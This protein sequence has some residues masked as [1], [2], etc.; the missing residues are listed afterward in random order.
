MDQQPSPSTLVPPVSAS[1]AL[2]QLA[3][4]VGTWRGEGRGVYPTI[5]AFDYVEEVTF[6]DVGKPFLVYHQRT[7]GQ[8]GAPMHVEVGYLRAPAAGVVELTMA[9][10]TGQTE[11]GSGT[12]TTDPLHLQLDC[13]VDNTPSAKRVDSSRRTLRVEGD[14]LETS[15]DMAAVGEPLHNHLRSRLTR[16]TS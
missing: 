13:R 14:V 1:H 16:L 6:V 3:P 9:L 10:P 5:E 11:N 7:W 15:F 12:F 4:L 2:A 8:D